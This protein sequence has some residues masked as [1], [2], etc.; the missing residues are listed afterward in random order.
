MTNAIVVQRPHPYS[1]QELLIGGRWQTGSAGTLYRNTNPFTGETLLEV[2]EASIDDI[3]AAFQAATLAQRDWAA[4]TPGERSQ[5]LYRAV[6]VLDARHAEVVDWLIKESGSVRTKAEIEW[7]AVRSIILEAATLPTRAWGR[8][9]PGDIP[10]KENRIYRKPVGV[11]SVISPWN[12]PLHLSTR[13]LAPA[14]ALGNA[15]VLKP[16]SETLVSGGLL[17]GKVFEEAGLPAGVLSVVSGDNNLIG[18]P[19]VLHP[20]SRVL[21][22]TGS[23]R[24]GKRIAGLATTGQV[25]KKVQLEMGG[26][27]PLVILDDADLDQAVDLAIVGRFLHQG[28]IC[29]SANRIIVQDALHDRFVEAFVDRVRGLKYGDPNA[30]DTVIGPLINQRQFDSVAMMI[31]QAHADGATLCFGAQPQGLVMPPHVFTNI[32][33]EVRLGRDE[34]FG[35]VAPVIR[36]ASEEQALHIANDTEY[37]LSSAVV[38]G[39]LDRGVRFAQRIEAGMTHVNDVP[40]VD[41]ANMPFGGEKNSGL[42]RFGA[43]GLIDDLTTEHWISV[44]S[45]RRQ[46][47]F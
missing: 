18:D 32:T 42:G 27:N 2:P 39:D 13:A 46:Y 44:Q 15:V 16:A 20:A 5:V 25:L 6:A 31:E 4:T 35:P 14:L 10:G 12:W 28:Q 11:V 7:A 36:A 17:L 45:T 24:V 40:A 22:F 8:I 29:V 30:A 9:I 33:G 21:S 1:F 3:N 23:T 43:Q 47:P 26:N 34:I 37:G 41:L 19:F 38:T